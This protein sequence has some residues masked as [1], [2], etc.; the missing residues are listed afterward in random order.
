MQTAGTYILGDR[1]GEELTVAY[2]IPRRVKEGHDLAGV[3][4]VGHCEWKDLRRRSLGE[5]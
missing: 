2:D 1:V 5:Y 4:S 3:L